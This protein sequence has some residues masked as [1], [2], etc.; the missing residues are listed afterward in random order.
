MRTW[1]AGLLALIPRSRGALLVHI[2]PKPW[3]RR[4]SLVEQATHLLPDFEAVRLT[5]RDVPVEAESL[6]LF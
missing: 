3:P 4:T 2:P 6:D 5:A 1:D